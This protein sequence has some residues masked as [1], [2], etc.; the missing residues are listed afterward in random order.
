MRSQKR[1]GL[2]IFAAVLA[3]VVAIGAPVVLLNTW[4]SA[5]GDDEVS[6]T[7]GWAVAAVDRQIGQTVS[8][9]NSLAARGA[10]SCKPAHLEMIRDLV[11]ASGLIK[12][13]SL[14][15]ADGQ[16]MCNEAG[17][18]PARRDVLGSSATSQSDIMLDVVRVTALGDRFLRVRKVGQGG[19]P[20]LAALVP[21]T[22]LLPHATLPSGR[23]LAFARMTLA[24][25]AV[26]GN[27]GI[28]SEAE[29]D[30]SGRDVQQ[31]RS[32]RYGVV[33]A[34]SMERGRLIARN[35]D[36]Q[37][38]GVVVTA[39]LAAMVLGFAVLLL[40]RARDHRSNDLAKAIF[41]NEFV[42]YYQP[43]VDIQTGQLHSAEVL[44]RW[45]QPDGSLVMPAAFIPAMESSGLIL[46]LTR[47][48]MRTVRNE[49]G[50]ALGK[51]PDMMVA[52]N[53]A[54]SHFG[55]A[56][57]LNDVGTIFDG[58]SIRLSQLIL[59]L[60][61][62]CEVENLTATRRTIAALQGLGCKVAIDDVGAGHSSLS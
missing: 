21:A 23:P 46:D 28:A 45:R 36:L 16:P 22:A 17:G 26:V 53:V 54:S 61:E 35:E 49:I 33:M 51:R 14:L 37:R 47:V 7:A 25:G 52:F 1:S 42:P 9:L 57:I 4:L 39:L 6:I 18:T 38:I 50:E 43:V 34:V 56:L 60:T 15:G 55:D 10:D 59:E 40:R 41:A 13:V 8:L 5:Q 58:S 27:T 48:L 62:R 44:V 3:G 19:K 30:Q 29:Y 32:Q 12:E 20:T 11:M 31:A 24:D 2:K